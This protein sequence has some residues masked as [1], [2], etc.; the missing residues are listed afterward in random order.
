MKDAGDGTVEISILDPSGQLIPNNVTS[1]Y[2]GAIQVFML[3]DC[4]S[5]K[6]NFI[7]FNNV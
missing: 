5:L 1:S 6:D 2:P 7:T 4:K 3:L